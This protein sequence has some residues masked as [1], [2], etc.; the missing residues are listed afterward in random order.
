MKDIIAWIK[1]QIT[2]TSDYVK[3]GALK[4]LGVAID[5]LVPLIVTL[6]QFPVWIDRSDE[7]TMSGLAII[8]LAICCVPFWRHIKAW[9][10]SPS[11]WGMWIIIFVFALLIRNIIDELWIVAL[12]G[13]IANCVGAVVYAIGTRVQR[14][15]MEHVVVERKE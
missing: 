4:L 9:L 8:I 13:S 15:G 3:G 10:K 6:T 14:R 11:N 12:W 2:G 5:V 7:A 1:K